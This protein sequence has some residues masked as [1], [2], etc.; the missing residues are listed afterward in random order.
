MSGL[1]P[2]DFIT[3]LL[4]RIDIVEIIELKIPLKKKGKEYMACCPFHGEKTP[5]FSVS[6][7]K[8]FYHCFGCGVHGTA[9]NFLMEYENLSFPEAIEYLADIAGMEVP[10]SA[11][12]PQKKTDHSAIALLGQSA[13]YFAQALQRLPENHPAK[14]YL[15]TR[16]LT[17]EVIGQYQ[18]GYAEN[19]IQNLQAQLACDDQSLV[20]TG[21][22]SEGDYGHYPRFRDRIMFPIRN[23]K[24]DVVGF[25]GRAIGDAQPKYL[26]SA[27]LDFFHKGEQLYGF[28]E[29]RKSTPR[30]SQL[31]VVE[32]Y[33]DVVALA[34]FGITYAVATLGTATTPEHASILTRTVRRITYCFDGDDAGR[35][36]AWKAL[37]NTLPALRDGI[38]VGFLF[39]PDGEDP[40]S[41]IRQIGRAAFETL[42]DEADRLPD[43]MIRELANAHDIKTIDGRANYLS[44][45]IPLLARLP[46]GTHLNTLIPEIANITRQFEDKI[47]RLIQEHRHAHPNPQAQSTNQTTRQSAISSNEVAKTPLRRAIALLLCSPHLLKDTRVE[48]ARARLPK[49]QGDQYF[50]LLHHLLE[51]LDN[52]PNSNTAMI[53][54]QVENPRMQQALSRL[55]TWRPIINDD[56]LVDDL[57]DAL[58]KLSRN[59][60]PQKAILE[61]LKKGETL[62]QWEQ[63]MLKKQPNIE[64]DHN[65]K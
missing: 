41:L 27:E 44:E 42:I 7:S 52:N 60:N 45:A 65:N 19:N 3:A 5:S 18:I 14:Q 54:A 8:Q 58:Q 40:D 30:L 16:N 64:N 21:L 17:P 47:W 26:N 56:L 59:H 2:Q 49:P 61:K 63:A 55:A 13:T 15:A 23:R 53:L 62:T 31:I 37:E 24:G 34:Q 38:S 35:K 51:I 22:L 57:V 4:E 50:E 29:A 46:D 39:L 25:G 48:Q 28:Y 9:I 32:G 20:K 12:A 6:Q 36:A 10:R 43:F 11:S 33:M 1:I